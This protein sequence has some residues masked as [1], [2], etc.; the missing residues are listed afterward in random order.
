MTWNLQIMILW[1]DG[2]KQ[3]HID[4]EFCALSQIKNISREIDILEVEINE[5]LMPQ[6]NQVL[7]KNKA[8]NQSSTNKKIKPQINAIH[9]TN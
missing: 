7:T 9:Y 2:L 5:H 1:V 4:I 6:I 8:P 3:N